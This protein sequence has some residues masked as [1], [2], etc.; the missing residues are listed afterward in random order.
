MQRLA[1]TKAFGERLSDP[2]AECVS[3]QVH[4]DLNTSD[5]YTHYLTLP[6]M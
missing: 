1:K 2:A 5:V 6:E 3:V 4:R